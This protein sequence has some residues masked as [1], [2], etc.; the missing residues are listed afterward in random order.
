[1]GLV[2]RNLNDSIETVFIIPSQ[3]HSFLS[4]SFV[5]EIAR[6]GGDVSKMVPPSVIKGLLD[7][8]A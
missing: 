7:L 4:S 8:T 5:K 1:M 6:H 2:N 3:E